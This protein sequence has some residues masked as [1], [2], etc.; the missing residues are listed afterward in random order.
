MA[1]FKKQSGDAGNVWSVSS[2][3]IC[4]RINLESLDAA[5]RKGFTISENTRALLFSID[6]RHLDQLPPGRYDK[7]GT[8][9]PK[10]VDTG[11]PVSLLL[12]AEAPFEWSLTVEPVTCLDGIGGRLHTLFVLRCTHSGRL[13]S[14]LDQDSEWTIRNLETEISETVIAALESA[15]RGREAVDLRDAGELLRTLV[16]Y[17]LIDKASPLLEGLDLELVSAG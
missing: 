12:S 16:R 5:F 2:P 13:F 8:E 14:K 1:L 17:A 9:L 4:K 10:G 7:G 6:G 3:L 11:K 15:V